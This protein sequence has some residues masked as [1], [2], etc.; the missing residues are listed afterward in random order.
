MRGF[1]ATS[2]WFW[3]ACALALT[4]GGLGWRP[5]FALA[6]AISVV[7]VLVA[8]EVESSLVS[9]RVQVRA[10][11][12]LILLAMWPERLH[13]LYWAPI[14][15]AWVR[16]LFDYCLLRRLLSLMP[17]NSAK[18]FSLQRVHEAF[19]GHLPSGN[20]WAIG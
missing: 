2:C 17:W 16:V 13:F 6:I 1:K 14:V 5:G 15:G 7:H 4:A 11:L 8:I 20:C 12:L 10:A 18:P 9:M 3:L 19:F